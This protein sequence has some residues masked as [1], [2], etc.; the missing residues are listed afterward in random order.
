MPWH[1]GRGVRYSSLV[2]LVRA[3]MGDEPQELGPK[4]CSRTGPMET[5]L[6]SHW[7]QILYQAMPTSLKLSCSSGNCDY[8]HHKGF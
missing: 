2:A 6:L 8:F 5:F 7:A 3:M 1:K 4:S